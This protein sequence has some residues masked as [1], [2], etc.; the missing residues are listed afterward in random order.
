MRNPHTFSGLGAALALLAMVTLARSADARI[1]MRP[2]LEQDE[3]F[4]HAHYSKEPF[5]PSDDFTLQIWNCASSMM[6]TFLSGAEPMVVC[7]DD[8]ATGY[9]AAVLVYSV[10]VPGGSCVDHAARATT[11][12]PISTRARAASGT[13]ASAMRR[14]AAGTASGSRAPATSPPPTRRTCSS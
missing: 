12:I 14:G 1:T 4:F 11:A 8:T 13:S 9:S 2:H 6:P 5:D 3:F 10:H 7:L